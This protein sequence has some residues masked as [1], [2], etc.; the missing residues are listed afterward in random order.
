[1]SSEHQNV[2]AEQKNVAFPQF[3]EFIDKMPGGK[4]SICTVDN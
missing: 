2:I 3:G 4:I 1:M